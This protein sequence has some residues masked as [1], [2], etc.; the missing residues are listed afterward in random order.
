MKSY[1]RSPEKALCPVCCTEEADLLWCVTSKQA[2]QHFVIY[3]KNPE[4]FAELVLHIDK[5]W[6]QST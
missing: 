3:E 6:G 2:A 1:Q 4:R 5:L